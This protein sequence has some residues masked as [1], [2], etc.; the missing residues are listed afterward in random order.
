M[1]ETGVAARRRPVTVVMGVIVLIGVVG[2]VL[3][4]M[5]G[6]GLYVSRHGDPLLELLG[7]AP[8]AYPAYVAP[9]AAGL[10][11]EAEPSLPGDHQPASVWLAGLA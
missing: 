4:V 8:R 9:A 5:V 11:L 6:A 2:L 7:G 1:E 3:A 10:S